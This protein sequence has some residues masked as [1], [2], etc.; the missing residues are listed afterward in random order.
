MVVLQRLENIII[1]G[2]ILVFG[3][4]WFDAYNFQNIFQYI[5]REKENVATC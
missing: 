1:K 3:M 4:K 5:Y 2:C